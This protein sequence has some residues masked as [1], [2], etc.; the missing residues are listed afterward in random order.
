MKAIRNLFIFTLMISAFSVSAEQVKGLYDTVKERIKHEAPLIIDEARKEGIDSGL[1]EIIQA[2]A[3][4]ERDLDDII[5]QPDVV[6]LG[7]E[8]Y[9]DFWAQYKETVLDLM[10][11]EHL[12]GDKDR[13]D[14][15]FTKRSQV[16]LLNLEKLIARYSE[17]FILPPS[18]VLSVRELI[19]YNDS[20][21]VEKNTKVCLAALYA[22][23]KHQQESKKEE[24]L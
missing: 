22:L 12:W 8:L 17:D 7:E 21:N 5:Q 23:K 20:I 16:I 11:L 13:S 10:A 14:E 15:Y 9:S 2:V 1:V 3:S 19:S 24:D 6:E 18:E 4:D